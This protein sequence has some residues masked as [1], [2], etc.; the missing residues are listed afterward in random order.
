M[1]R[2]FSSPVRRRGERPLPRH[3]SRAANPPRP[4]SPS[5][6]SCPVPVSVGGSPLADASAWFFY[7][8]LADSCLVQKV[9]RRKPPHPEKIFFVCRSYSPP[10]LLG[11][12]SRVLRGGK[13]E[14]F[15]ALHSGVIHLVGKAGRARAHREV[16][17]LLVFQEGQLRFEGHP[18]VQAQNYLKSRAIGPNRN[19]KAAQRVENFPD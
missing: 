14:Y 16:G 5:A 4:A 7:P 3:P 12:A 2:F 13:I 19:R 1:A 6:G 8:G 11:A 15:S 10:E 9:P 17:L 18:T